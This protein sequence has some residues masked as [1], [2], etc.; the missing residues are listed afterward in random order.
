MRMRDDQ[1][2]LSGQ[3]LLNCLEGFYDWLQNADQNELE[4]CFSTAASR[5]QSQLDRD[6]VDY[7]WDQEY[8]SIGVDLQPNGKHGGDARFGAFPSSTL[9]RKN[10]TGRISDGPNQ[11]DLPISL[12]VP[13]PHDESA[14]IQSIKGA[15]MSSLAVEI[16]DI[17]RKI[18]KD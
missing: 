3:E 5:V 9:H 12:S 7:T 15:F 18:H 13:Y 11:D 17:R 8:F 6:D 1:T 14:D 4:D 10:W 2:S 16:G